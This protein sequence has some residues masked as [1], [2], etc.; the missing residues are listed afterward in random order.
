MAQ[1]RITV[2]TPFEN[3]DH[4]IESTI[5]SVVDQGYDNLEY[6]LIDTGSTDGSLDIVRRYEQDISAWISE[7][8]NSRVKAINQGLKKATGD[9][10]AVID[11]DCTLLPGALHE[12][13]G[14]VA[15]SGVRWLVGDSLRI[16]PDDQTLG[17]TTAGTPNSFASFLMHDSGW[18]P[19]TSS[20]WSRSYLNTH[21]LFD[22]Q[23]PL[24]FDYEYSCRLFAAGETPTILH[25][26]LSAQRELLTP[27]SPQNTLQTGMEYIETAH[28]YAHQLPWG[29]RYALWMNCDTRRRIYA[30]AEAETYG[31]E[32]RRYLIQQLLRHPWWITSDNMRRG[33]IRGITHPL[34]NHDMRPAA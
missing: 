2:I 29:Q 6:L 28:R 17:T 32:G 25:M 21:G 20:F 10:V 16:G 18:L 9:F 31:Q 27:E 33:L 19:L 3:H 23:L 24:T 30:L 4:H 11:A 22:E 5:C 34:P 1:P 12:V 8:C 14:R 15:S 13:A 26:A 7:P